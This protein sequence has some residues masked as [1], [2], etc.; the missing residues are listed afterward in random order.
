MEG[1]LFNVLILSI[2]ACF[3]LSLPLSCLWEIV[4]VSCYLVNFGRV[5]VTSQHLDKCLED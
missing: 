5:D 2:S 3:L 4:V 1:A